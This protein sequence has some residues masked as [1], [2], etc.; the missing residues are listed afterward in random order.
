MGGFVTTSGNVTIR[1]IDL[2]VYRYLLDDDQAPVPPAFS[3][4]VVEEDEINDKSKGDMV[5]KALVVWQTAWFVIQIVARGVGGLA[6]TELEIMTLA[7]G[8]MCS[9]LYL[10][11]WNKP[12]DIQTP[13]PTEGP[14][15][16]LLQSSLQE[17]FPTRSWTQF[18]AKDILNG[19]WAIILDNIIFEDTQS[20]EVSPRLE[21]IAAILSFIASTLFGCI[22]CVAWNFHFPT[23]FER[24]LWISSSLV[25]A[26]LPCLWTGILIFVDY[27]DCLTWFDRPSLKQGGLVILWSV[28]I[29][30]YCLA[31]IILIIQAFV[32]LRDLPPS[33]TQSISWVD[34]F[35][36]I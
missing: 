22:H 15:P 19:V 20:G 21:E 23:P 1:P 7:Y 12:Y 24:L 4:P 26:A 5:T 18:E 28:T 11:W 29:C 32:L 8:L 2:G 27:N 3:W 14:A 17:V 10:L 35:P 25:V 6:I 13:I 9:F 31:R 34:F 33:A 16:N 30:T 36:H